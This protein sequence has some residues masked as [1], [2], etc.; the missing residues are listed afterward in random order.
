MDRFNFVLKS[1]DGKTSSSMSA[2]MIRSLL[3][4]RGITTVGTADDNSVIDF[5]LSD[6]SYVRFVVGPNR[7]DV[8]YYPP[9]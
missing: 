3:S 7:A 2:E 9:S 8:E 5:N 4:K 6:G 1:S